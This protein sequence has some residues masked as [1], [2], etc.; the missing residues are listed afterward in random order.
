MVLYIFGVFFILFCFSLFCDLSEINCF[1]LILINVKVFKVLDMY[2]GFGGKFF[3]IIDMGDVN[4][5][6]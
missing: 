3:L 6:F 1:F 5:W 4:I 2:V